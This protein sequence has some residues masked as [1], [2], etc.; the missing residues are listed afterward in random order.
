MARHYAL[1]MGT[2]EAV[3]FLQDLT[4]ELETLL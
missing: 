2:F 4:S 3:R 1:L